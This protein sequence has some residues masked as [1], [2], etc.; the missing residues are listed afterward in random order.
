MGQKT[1]ASGSDQPLIKKKKIL[2]RK[3]YYI[4]VPKFKSI[5]SQT[6]NFFVD[7]DD[8]YNRISTPI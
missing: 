4:A 1:W 5:S 6:K 2:I 3:P 8:N 7:D